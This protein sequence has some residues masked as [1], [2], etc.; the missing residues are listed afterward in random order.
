MPQKLVPNSSI[1]EHGVIHV[2]RDDGWI[3]SYN[4]TIANCIRSNRDVT[5]TL[6]TSK[7][8]AYIYYLTNNYICN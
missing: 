4:P 1:N 3:T 6:T 7:A 5:W 2:K 8:L